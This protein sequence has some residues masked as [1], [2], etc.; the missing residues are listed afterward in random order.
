MDHLEV[1]WNS[2]ALSGAC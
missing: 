2:A 1:Q